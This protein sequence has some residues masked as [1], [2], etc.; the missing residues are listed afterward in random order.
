MPID[1]EL[2]RGSIYKIKHRRKGTFI[3]KLIDVVQAEP[4]D[5][6]DEIFLHVIYDVRAGTDQVG[7]AIVPGKDRE[8]ESNLRPSLIEKIEE[9]EGDTWLREVKLPKAAKAADKK[10]VFDKLRDAFG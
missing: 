2:K 1:I 7:L 9:F 6:Q 5:P 4:D 8:R 10:S 3:A